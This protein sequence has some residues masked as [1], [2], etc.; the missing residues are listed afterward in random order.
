MSSRARGVA[1]HTSTGALRRRS[2]E[3]ERAAWPNRRESST[4]TWSP[5]SW[6][7]EA[8]MTAAAIPHSR[9]ELARGVNGGI[10]VALFRSAKDNRPT[11]EVWQAATGE[12]LRFTVARTDAPDRC[13][14]LL[15]RRTRRGDARALDARVGANRTLTARCLQDHAR[16]RARLSRAPAIVVGRDDAL[17]PCHRDQRANGDRLDACSS[18]VLRDPGGHLLEYLAT[19]DSPPDP[20]GR[21]VPWSQWI[22]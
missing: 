22:T 12:T 15:G 18:G 4:S 21:I 6:R 16:E 1:R 3:G 7:G 19:L 11:V 13:R 8:A 9:R 20:E 5:P 2:R 17:L 10:E 14:V